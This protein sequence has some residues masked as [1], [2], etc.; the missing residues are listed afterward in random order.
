MEV[1]VRNLPDQLTEKQVDNFFRGVLEKLGIHTYFCQKLKGRGCATITILDAMKA[2]KFLS[3]HGQTDPGSRGYAKVQLKLQHKGRQIYCSRSNKDPDEHILLSLKKEESDRYALQIRKAKIVPA[4]VEDSNSKSAKPRAWSIS[5]LLCGQWTYDGPDLMFASYFREVR[6]GR[7]VFGQRTLRINLDPQGRNNPKHQI[8]IPYNSIQSFT[9]G[10]KANP[11]I[12]LSLS[13]AP[14]FFE[15][16]EDDSTGVSD[17]QRMLQAMAISSNSAAAMQAQKM[18]RDIRIRDPT[19]QYKRK[20]I[21]ALNSI[22]QEVVASCLCYR[23]VLLN[24]NDIAGIIALKR[25]PMIPGSISWSTSITQRPPF[26]RQMT[27]LKA[28]LTEGTY[29]IL[30]FGLKFQLQKL[31]QNGYL[32]PTAV[33]GLLSVVYRHLQEANVAVVIQSVRNLFGWI[34]FAGPDVE[35]SE[36]SLETLTEFLDQAK[37]SILREKSY[38]NGLADRYE[39]IASIQKAMVTPAGV[40]LYGPEPEVVNR[41]LRKYSAFSDHFLSVSFLEEDGEPLRL[42]RQTSGEEIYHGRYKSVLQTGINIANRQYEVSS[43]K[44]SITLLAANHGR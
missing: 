5:E 25:F 7:V 2:R 11:C 15:Q 4:K 30:P 14:R 26:T 10:H 8:E 21:N 39:H 9:T 29:S 36:L 32:S 19:P 24:A 44:I 42:D 16:L 43:T 22:H 3:V 37:I 40:Y 17:M 18:L 31:A 33:L 35:S 38:S 27:A 28:A 23:L 41:V 6:K 1:I 20:R 13:E 12:T 34:P